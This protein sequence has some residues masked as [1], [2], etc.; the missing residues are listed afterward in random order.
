MGFRRDIRN[1]TTELLEG[2][3][4]GALKKPRPDTSNVFSEDTA[5]AR[6]LLSTGA[7]EGGGYDWSPQEPSRRSYASGYVRGA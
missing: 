1:L 7:G 6:R 2:A 3:T 4:D 5:D